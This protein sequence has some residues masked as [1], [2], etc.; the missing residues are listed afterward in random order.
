[1]TN[2]VEEFLSQLE[3]PSGL[4][5]QEG[6]FRTQDDNDG[7]KSTGVSVVIGPDGDAWV[8]TKGSDSHCRRSFA[9]DAQGADSARGS[10]SVG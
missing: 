8:R 2:P 4:K 7:D 9:H 10:H 6:Y 5:L 1:M 3:W